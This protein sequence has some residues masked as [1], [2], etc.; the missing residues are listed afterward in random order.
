MSKLKPTPLAYEDLKREVARTR[1]EAPEDDRVLRL[2][3]ADWLLRQIERRRRTIAA[4]PSGRFAYV[5][6]EAAEEM[7]PFLK[8]LRRRFSNR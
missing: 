4:C 2:A 7:E 3:S 6:R 8:E 1:G 5:G